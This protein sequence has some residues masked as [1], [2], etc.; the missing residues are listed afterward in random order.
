[1]EADFIKSGMAFLASETG[2]L[3]RTNLSKPGMV[4]PVRPAD[5]ELTLIKPGVVF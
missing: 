3:K 5:R 2:S 1:M 4:L